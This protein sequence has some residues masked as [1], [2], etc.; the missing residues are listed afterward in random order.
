MK[1]KI[2]HTLQYDYTDEVSLDPHIIYLFPKLNECLSLQ[3][4]NLEI[5]PKPSHT[6]QN[7][8]LEGNIQTVCFFNKKTNKLHLSSD[9]EVDTIVFNPFDFVFFPFGASVL[10]FQYSAEEQSVL[11]AYKQI[12]DIPTIVDNLARSIAAE[13]NWATAKFLMNLC[14]FINK[15]FTYNIRE[16][17]LPQT[18][19][20]TLLNKSGSCRDYSVFFIACCRVMGL[21]AR[22][23]SGYYYSKTLSKN[24]LH[25]WVEV[26][27]PG[28]GWRA[29]DPTQNNAVSNLHIPIAASLFPEKIG[30]VTGTFR[31]H[32]T[33]SLTTEV[34]VENII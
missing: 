8:D 9:I 24:Y 16:E 4:F 6:Y 19:E 14:N 2:S 32:A 15:N 28:G 13:A 7:I 17:G 23:V 33:S 25:A 1:I 30:P 31:G 27:L 12:T 20:Y 5:F 29:F 11:N 3:N 21:A 10:P 26:Y 34:I 22:F 18:P